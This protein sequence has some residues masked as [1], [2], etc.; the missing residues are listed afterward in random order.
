VDDKGAHPPQRALT[1]FVSY[2]REDASGHAGRLYDALAG[3]FGA[4]NVFIDVDTIAPGTDYTEAIERAVT[5]CDVFIALIGQAWLTVTDAEGRRR[6]EQPTDVVRLE[7]ES[8]LSRDLVVIPTCVHG[9][10]IPPADELPLSLA[11]LA[12]RQAI[13]LR[14]TVW[15]EDVQRLIRRLE[16]I[17]TQ[18]VPSIEVGS[19]FTPTSGARKRSERR[20]RLLIAAGGLL[21][22]GAVGLA[23]ALV[24]SG[25]GGDRPGSSANAA[26]R[27]SS[28]STRKGGK[29]QLL[30]LIS[31]V[32]R[33]SCKSTQYPL[34]GASASVDCGTATLGVTYGLFASNQVM[35]AWYDS[36]LAD[37]L[38]D[39]RP[40][41]GGCTSSRF[42]GESSYRVSGQIA[43]RYFCYVARD[44]GNPNLVATDIRHHVGSALQFYGGSSPAGLDSFLRQWRDLRV[45]DNG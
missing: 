2:R 9:A 43:G 25:G 23:V 45:L 22:L 13:E 24:A 19:A 40:G 21:A 35:H 3:W 15:H 34:Q 11:P 32:I 29:A 33:S 36:A 44:D 39:F 20:T 8:A 7:L 12:L 31:P 6:L 5:N 28:A 16:R 30:A 4:Q 27:E 26:T 17:A 10:E 42:H 41:T 14:D 18:K 37:Y 1:V 38:G